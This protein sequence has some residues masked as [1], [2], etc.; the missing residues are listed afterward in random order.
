MPKQNFYMGQQ[1]KKIFSLLANHSG[2]WISIANIIILRVMGLMI[3]SG[4]LF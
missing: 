3:G 4:Q 1:T 2:Y